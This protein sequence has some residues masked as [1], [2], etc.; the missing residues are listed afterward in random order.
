MKYTRRH[1]FLSS[2]IE[3]SVSFANPDAVRNALAM[4]SEL[5]SKDS[6]FCCNGFSCMLY[7]LLLDPAA[8]GIDPA[9]ANSGGLCTR[10]CRSR[11]THGFWAE[12]KKQ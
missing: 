8:L 10:W 9:I 3:Y 7:Q 4:I 5:A 11:T 6:Y 12:V 1:F 2:L